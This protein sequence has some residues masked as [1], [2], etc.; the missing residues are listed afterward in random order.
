LS[1][2]EAKDSIRWQMTT[3]AEVTT[4]PG[5]AILHQDGKTLRLEVLEPEGTQ[6]TVTSLNPPPH[7][8]DR[9]MPGLK[10]IDVTV[11]GYIGNT[12][13]QIRVRLSRE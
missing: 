8:M 11:P 3:Q 7:E 5:G 13:F 10:R 9:V 6:V 1:F 2:L 4:M 12:K